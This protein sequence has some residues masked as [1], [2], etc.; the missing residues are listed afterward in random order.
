MNWLVIEYDEHGNNHGSKKFRYHE[1]AHAYVENNKNDLPS[2]HWF[3]I[4]YIG[5]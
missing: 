1:N 2:N 3:H 5:F 4:A